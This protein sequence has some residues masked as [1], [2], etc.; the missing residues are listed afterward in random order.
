MKVYGAQLSK[1]HFVSGTVKN[2]GIP[3]YEGWN[4]KNVKDN[5]EVI[6]AYLAIQIFSENEDENT[7][8]TLSQTYFSENTQT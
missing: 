2:I 8:K 3:Y 4:F 5:G 1:K 6:S 7:V